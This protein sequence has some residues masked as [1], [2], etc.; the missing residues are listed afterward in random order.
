MARPARPWCRFLGALATLVAVA[1]CGSNSSSSGVPRSSP[2]APA[3]TTTSPATTGPPT[4]HLALVG[5]GGA[6]G[7]ISAPQVQCN[8]PSLTG[9]QIRVFATAPG[10]GT[11]VIVAIHAGTISVRYDSGAGASYRERDFSGTGLTGFDPPHGVQVSSPL[12]ET[13]AAG[14]KTGG[15]RLAFARSH[16][17]GGWVVRELAP[18]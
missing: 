11:T 8:E 16:A 1:A 5:T 2:S 10:K 4:A 12:S 6:A 13:T 18:S 17:G 9:P 7:H 14:G 3:T 15:R